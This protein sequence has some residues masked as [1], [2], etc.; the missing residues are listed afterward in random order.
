[1]KYFIVAGEQSG[2][3]HGS[4]L[5]K[6]LLKR[7][8]EAVIACWGGDLMQ[9]AGAR[10]LMHYKKTAI[11]GITAVV[12]NLGTFIRNLS[13]CR[14][15]IISFRP[16]VVILIDFP[17]F[18]L[19]LAK[20][21]KDLDQGIKIF[22]YISP[23]FWAW[24]EYR[25]KKIKKSIDRMFIIFPFEKDFY[26]KHGIQV[27]YYGNPLVDETER[28]LDSL[29]EKSEI[30]K[31]LALS[32]KPLIALL[33]GSRKHEVR[34]ILP[35]M[36]SITDDLPGYQF[37]IAGVGNLPDD[38]YKIIIGDKPVKIVKDK[39]YEILKVADAALVA[40]GTAT[41][42]TALFNVP[43]VVCYKGDFLSMLIAWI[44]IKVKYVSLVN[45][46]LDK[47]AVKELLGYSLTSRNLLRETRDILPGGA[48]R[49]QML[50]DY[51]VIRTK[52]GPAGASDR[53]ALEMIN[54][55]KNRTGDKQTE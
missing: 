47:E 8:N 2:D 5:V 31:S 26:N 21:I 37:V 10:L 50:S 9:E 13:L 38:L 12:K 33:A 48:G 53:I 14:D 51:S 49:N 27:E 6:A 3:L 35:K 28:R 4:N 16:D 17:G 34:A 22:Y 55:L 45:L 25:I 23:K 30:L 39:T 11:M 1:M 7:D 54:A 43:Q 42:E 20:K 24:G 15:Q 40:S 29:P 52:L 44:M 32:E 19:R 46:L 41:L 36:I 18:N